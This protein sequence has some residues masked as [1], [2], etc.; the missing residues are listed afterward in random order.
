MAPSTSARYVMK[1]VVCR[2]SPDFDSLA[3]PPNPARLR[4]PSQHISQNRPTR[5]VGNRIPSE[6]PVIAEPIDSPVSLL[7][8]NPVVEELS[9]FAVVSTA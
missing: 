5:S 4:D 9:R 3:N 1:P 6:D 8:P 2:S 7:Q